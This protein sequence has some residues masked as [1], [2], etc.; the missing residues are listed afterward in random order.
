ME[1]D[2]FSEIYRIWTETATTTQANLDFYVDAYVAARG[3]VVELGVG[4]GRI[5]L[6]AARRGRQVIGVDSSQAMLTRCREQAARDGISARLSL[7]EA[8][9]RT[10]TLQEPAGLIALPYHSLGHLSSIDDKR[11]ALRQIHAQ[12]MPGGLFMFDDLL[13]TPRHL[14]YVRRVQLRAEYRSPDGHDVLLWVTSLV[15]EAMQAMRVITWEDELDSDGVLQRRRYRPLSL[16]W[17]EPHQSRQ[18][19]EETGFTIDA[20]YGDFRRTPFDPEQATEQIWIA[21]RREAA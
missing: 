17:L 10:F 7:M 4:D 18:L 16:T 3:P 19:L 9:F 13:M 15:D 8:D 6:A 2:R 12:L 1:Y 11:E 21:R 20:C 14:E 5:A